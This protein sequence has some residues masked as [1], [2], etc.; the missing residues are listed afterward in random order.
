MDRMSM[1][2][3]I[4]QAMMSPFVHIRIGLA[5]PAEHRNLSLA[6]TQGLEFKYLFVPEAQ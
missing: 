2:R 6:L 4:R 1:I 3:M 5:S